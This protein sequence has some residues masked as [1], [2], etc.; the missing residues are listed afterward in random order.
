M[1]GVCHELWVSDVI[2]ERIGLVV[3]DVAPECERKIAWYK[4]SRGRGI[5]LWT[6]EDGR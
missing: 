2:P 4:V 1:N 6:A 5:F 3:D